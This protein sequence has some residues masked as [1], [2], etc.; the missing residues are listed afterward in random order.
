MPALISCSALPQT[1][2]EKIRERISTFIINHKPLSEQA[3]LDPQSTSS[4][5]IISKTSISI[6]NKIWSSARRGDTPGH[7]KDISISI[8]FLLDVRH[9]RPS[10][11]Q[12]FPLHYELGST[13]IE[14]AEGL[15]YSVCMM[16]PTSVNREFVTAIR[17]VGKMLQPPSDPWRHLVASLTNVWVEGAERELSEKRLR[18]YVQLGKL[19]IVGHKEGILRAISNVRIFSAEQ[20]CFVLSSIY[21]LFVPAR[22]HLDPKEICALT[23]VLVRLLDKGLHH[24]PFSPNEHTDFWLYVMMSI[25]DEGTPVQHGLRMPE[26]TLAEGILVEQDISVY[27]NGMTRNPD[28]F[29][30]L[31]QLSN[32]LLGSPPDTK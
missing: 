25:L 4:K 26:L 10:W 17:T 24:I 1:T 32:K 31:L 8:L 13:S 11:H 9:I 2:F 7:A 23:E 18:A 6:F 27:G 21:A 30:R 22:G 19:S 28:I 14:E 5:Q 3:I 29:R 20:W 15:A 16:R 12:Y